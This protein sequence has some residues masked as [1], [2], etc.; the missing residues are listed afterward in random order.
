MKKFPLKGLVVGA[1]MATMATACVSGEKMMVME[2]SPGAIKAVDLIG[3]WVDSGAPKTGFT[4]TDM[5]GNST[6]GDF[7]TDILPLFTKEG[8]WGEGTASCTSCHFDN[9]EESYHEMDLS[10]YEGIMKGGDVLSQPPGVPLFGQS[11]IGAADYDW[12]HSKMRARLRNNRMPPGVEFDITEENRDGP[13][14]TEVGTIEAW[15]AAGAK[16]DA[17][18][19]SKILPLF[20]TDGA[21][22]EGTA[23]CTSCHF[24]NSEDSYHEM[25]LSSYEGIMKGGDVLSQPPG[26]PLFGQS[27]VGATD[28]DWG[29]SKMKERLRNNRMPPSIEFDITEENRDGPIVAHGM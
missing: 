3:A 19:S 23:S 4:Y 24:D 12:G 22:G 11:Q 2:S 17:T 8:I 13:T 18:F 5:S 9:S 6:L 1:V 27:K 7:T 10:S 14:G 21:W 16:N 26:V 25:D 28:Y 15:V 20:T 29:H